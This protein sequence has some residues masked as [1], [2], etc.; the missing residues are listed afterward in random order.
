MSDDDFITCW[1]LNNLRPISAKINIL[2]GAK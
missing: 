1:S 2:K